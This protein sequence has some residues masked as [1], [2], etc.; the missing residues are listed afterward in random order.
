[1]SQAK[2]ISSAS[3]KKTQFTF[4]IIFS[5]FGNPD[6]YSVSILYENGVRERHGNGNPKEKRIKIDNRMPMPMNTNVERKGQFLREIIAGL[7]QNNNLDMM[8]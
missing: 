2:I 8:V 3:L 1:M 6:S 4:L 5:Q 7:P